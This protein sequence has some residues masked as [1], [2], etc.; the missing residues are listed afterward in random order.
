MLERAEGDVLVSA[1]EAL[2]KGVLE[3]EVPL[4]S[5]LGPSRGVFKRLGSI[6][7]EASAERL[8]ASHG[9][10]LEIVDEPGRAVELGA[11]TC[12]SGRNVMLMLPAGDILR[13]A[14]ALVRVRELLAGT[15]G[16]GLLLL[17]EDDVER[18]DRAAPIHL[19][20]DLA[21]A[22]IEPNDVSDL[23]DMVEHG[24]R[25]SRAGNGPAAIL[26]SSNILHAQDT[27]RLRPN[28]VVDTID[29]A[30]AMRRRRRVG[31]G[32]EGM[33]LLRLARRLEL[34]HAHG[35]PSP[36]ELAPLGLVAVGP[37][38]SA[39]EY[40]LR[41]FGLEGRVPLLQ[42]GMSSPLDES[43]TER[44][45]LRCENVVVLETRPGVVGRELVGAAEAARRKGGTAASV[46]WRTLPPQDGQDVSLD[47]GDA[48]RASRVARKIS[49]MLDAVSTGRTVTR[50]LAPSDRKLE[51]LEVPPRGASSGVEGAIRTVRNLL[52][53]TSQW[54]EER[55]E[56]PDSERVALQLDD[57]VDASAYD[58]VVQAE[59]WGR[60][61]FLA[62]GPAAI[63]EC[64][65]D[66]RPR[67]LV[68][69]D[70]G[71][72]SGIDVVRLATASVPEEHGERVAVR[73]T[74]LDDLDGVL[75]LLRESV[76]SNQ[77][78]VLVA[79]DGSPPRFDR[80]AVE[81][82][83]REV[84][85]L[86]F[87]PMQRVVRSAEQACSLRAPVFADLLGT[88]LDRNSEELE[89][90]FRLDTLPRRLG[91]G[92][93][94][95]LRPLTEQ[96]E[97]VRTQPPVIQQHDS[98]GNRPAVP[99]IK[100][101]NASVWRCHVAGWRG[102][103]PGLVP[104]IISEAGRAMGY[105]VGCVVSTQPAGPGRG[106]WA[107]LL[108]TRPRTGSNPALPISIPYGE[109]DVLVGVDPVETLRAIGPD[110][111][112]RVAAAD[113]TDAVVNIG[114]LTDQEEHARA[115]PRGTRELLQEGI[116]Q[117]CREQ[118]WVFDLVAPAR[119]TLLTERLID[120]MLLGIT[121]QRGLI[122]VSIE[123]LERVIERTERNEFGR[124]L[125]AFR[126]GRTLAAGL[127]TPREPQINSRDVE[128]MIRRLVRGVRMDAGR[129]RSRALRFEALLREGID[130]MPGLLETA[131]GRPAVADYSIGLRHALV[132]G[133]FSLAEQF[134]QLVCGLYNADS[135]A[136]SRR[137]TCYAIYPLIEVLLP[138]DPIFIAAM[139]SSMEQRLRIRERLAVRHARGDRIE[140]RYLTRL[141]LIFARRRF[142]LDF[143]TSNW[144]A[145][146]IRALGTV[147]P[148]GWRGNAQERGLSREVVALVEEATRQASVDPER[149]EA[150]M[151]KLNM[152]AEMGR[153]RSMRPADLR[154][155]IAQ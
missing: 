95:R 124:L 154:K 26:A 41:R 90:S 121:F 39:A 71:M 144:A 138:R 6:T 1:L 7:S 135:G 137:M 35:F 62:D 49:H 74:S 58:R 92:L 16:F 5:V 84:D 13:S 89:S 2:L 97:V 106:A 153:L 9:C 148:H 123:V 56:E 83:F 75:E 86:G 145:W 114:L 96:V 69:C 38:Y 125:V 53:A 107:Q 126:H 112:L 155:L 17:I 111:T 78:T 150:V 132:W 88:G 15:E 140:R 72:Q 55:D 109:A 130:Q 122:P 3:S 47:R 101:S 104:R 80:A 118:P 94:V 36:G 70:I 151:L 21:I 65:V 20:D 8:F 131:R 48:L 119:R 61:R 147:V 82:S 116:D 50:G 30:A 60:Q 52:T 143:R 120:M 19:L 44:L 29:V 73:S 28:R 139:T 152:Q 27:I 40:L 14:N 149:W 57:S 128:P 32:Y 24:I 54:L 42:L 100:H 79:R 66:S 37:A 98:G 11:R 77:V 59:I 22:R 51:E 141:E 4:H 113:R 117:R 67:I 25:L 127:P 102:A 43:I 81:R 68:I 23:R 103:E 85:R 129:R 46:W 142:R 34:N 33:E 110:P 12:L 64:A 99:T 146:A 63:R 76:L 115:R 10:R 87:T 91:R 133:G 45:F 105:R 108:F 136:R 93:L 134:S 18:L 31:R